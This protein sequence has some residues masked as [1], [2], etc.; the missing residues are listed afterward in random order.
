MNNDSAK[1]CEIGATREFAS[2]AMET[3]L[4]HSPARAFPM[5]TA[6]ELSEALADAARYG[7]FDECRAYLDQ[8]ALADA[9]DGLLFAAANGH[10]EIVSLFL[11]YGADVNKTNDQGSTAM[12]WACLNGHANIV[13]LLL[14]KG[15]SASVCNQAGRT[16]LDEAMH[17]EREECVKVI[18]EAEGEQ[19]IELEEIDEEAA[20]DVSTDEE[21]QRMD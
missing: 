2:A 7:E 13:Q 3:A 17:N 8:G 10:V 9:Y 1:T 18:M 20:E 19:D 6:E 21:E 15:G 11:E 5:S 4:S 16:P 12:H 14:D